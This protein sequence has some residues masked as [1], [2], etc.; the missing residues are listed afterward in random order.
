M[1][2]YDTLQKSELAIIHR[3]TTTRSLSSQGTSLDTLAQPTQSTQKEGLKK[4]TSRALYKVRTNHILFHN[5]GGLIHLKNE[6]EKSYRNTF[7]CCSKLIQTD[8]G[9]VVSEYCNNRWCTVCNHIKTGKMINGYEPVVEK[10]N[11]LR[12]VTLTRPN[13]F[14]GLRS[15]Y[16]K[17]QIGWKT[18]LQRLRRNGL[19]TEG[20]RKNETA[21][22]SYSGYNLHYHI[23]LDGEDYGN[24]LVDEWLN[25][26]TT[27]KSIGQDHRKGDK[28]SIKEL[29]KYM[30]KLGTKTKTAKGVEYIS[31]YPTKV[32]DYI[33][34]SMKGK[35]TIQ[36]FGGVKRVSEDLDDLDSRLV[37]DEARNVAWDWDTIGTW[38]DKTTG[39]LRTEAQEPD[40]FLTGEPPKLPPYGTALKQKIRE[41][42]EVKKFA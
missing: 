33:F 27:A 17:L 16:G 24:A 23:L 41:L 34:Q 26:N 19:K 13:V 35:R 40:E 32:L 11:D 37:L 25:V 1:Q 22:K 28:N 18:V 30:T 31:A 9:K 29:F 7:Y 21:W 10:W 36:T 3:R 2:I 20:I 38:I 8:D 12:F 14:K 5:G 15:E 39:E 42:S 6:M 4:L